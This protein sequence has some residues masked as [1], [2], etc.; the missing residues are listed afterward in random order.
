MESLN[1]QMYLNKTSA[2][3]SRIAYLFEFVSIKRMKK[4]KQLRK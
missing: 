4:Y 1:E 2:S 3:E